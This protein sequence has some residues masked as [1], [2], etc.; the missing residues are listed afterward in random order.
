M[1]PYS[2]E[3]KN[4]CEV[5]PEELVRKL[6]G[7]YSGPVWIPAVARRRIKTMGMDERDE[8]IRELYRQ[9][10]SIGE[11]AASVL[12]SKERVRQIIRRTEDGR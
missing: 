5:L 1:R 7:I 10:R 9:G 8:K 11:I 12:L 2:N 6:Q 3:Y 4:A